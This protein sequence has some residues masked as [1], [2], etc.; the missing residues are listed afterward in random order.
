VHYL[1]WLDSGRYL[2]EFR[3][4]GALS[5]NDASTVIGTVTAWDITHHTLFVLHFHETINRVQ[6][7]PAEVLAG[8]QGGRQTLIFF[9]DQPPWVWDIAGDLPGFQP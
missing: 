1:G 9:D 4:H 3:K 6:C 5:R 2:L 7:P 8:P